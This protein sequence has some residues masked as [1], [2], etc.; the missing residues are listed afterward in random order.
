MF[1]FKS[2]INVTIIWPDES[3]ST[4]L[5]KKG[6]SIHELLQNVDYMK[7]EDIIAGNMNNIYCDLHEK[8][9][10][11]SVIQLISLKTATGLQI[12]RNTA[13]LILGYAIAKIFNKNILDIGP[14][15]QFNY[16]FDLNINKKVSKSMLKRINKEFDSIVNSNLPIESII[17]PRNKAAKY[18]EKAGELSKAKLLKNLQSKTIKIYKIGNYYDICSKPVGVNTSIIQKYKFVLY[19]PGFLIECPRVEDNELKILNLAKTNKLS[20][21]F[22]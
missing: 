1:L 14:S 4:H 11:H 7:K 9:K 21:L 5:L 6:M 13:I 3:S 15:I 22:L 19:S 12:Y 18:F 16:F 17:L 8:I 10:K 20:K 2:K